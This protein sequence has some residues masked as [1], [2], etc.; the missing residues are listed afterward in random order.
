M[1]SCRALSQCF[2]WLDTC[3]KASHLDQIHA[4]VI[5]QGL[6]GDKR[7]SS[8]IL[9]VCHKLLRSQSASRSKESGTSFGLYKQLL[10]CGAT[11]SGVTFS[12]VL[13]ACSHLKA[14]GLVMGIHA[15]SLALG[16]RYDSLVLNSLIHGYVACELVGA[17]HEVFDELPDRDC[18]AWTELING[19]ARSGCA[20]AALDLFL[21]MMES[22]V[23]PDE[24][25]IVAV[26]TAFSQ[27]GSASLARMA[28]GLACKLGA[29]DNSYVVNALIDMHGKCGS[30]SDAWELFDG[31]PQKDVV[32]YN[33][34]VAGFARNGDMETAKRLFHRIP[35]KNEVSWSSLIN[36]YLQNDCFREVLNAYTEMIDHGRVVPNAAAITC[37]VAA[38]AHLGALDLGRKIHMNLDETKL[39]VDTVLST[40]LVD[41]YAKCGCISSACALFGRIVQKSEVSWNVMIMGLAI[42]GQAAECLELFSEMLKVG[43][44]PTS[45]TFTGVL[46]ACAHVGWLEVGKHYFEKMTKLYRISPSPEHLCCM[47]HLLGRAGLISEAFQLVR[48][49]PHDPDAATWGALLSSCRRHGYVE[50]GDVIARKILELEP[51][52]SG[53]FVQLSSMLASA[54]KWREVQEIRKIMKERGVQNR[55]GW[56][57]F[58]LDGTVH[59]FVI[60]VNSHPRIIDIYRVLQAIDHHM[61][62]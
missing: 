2:S 9:H 48:D 26:C 14:P 6:S 57:W 21:R 12:L 30:V 5:A 8:V 28:E 45:T 1:M 23:R 17:A 29:M 33:S 46:S 42:H 38:C 15:Q 20:E 40:A 19:Y 62:G 35:N 41:M 44:K 54:S 49:S 34:M 37:T 61:N 50:L 31:L 22:D 47:V 11:P 13:K 60:G 27:F 24:F 56:S 36:G 53:A 16:F 43:M 4:Q 58:E 39:C 25:S 10:Q 55:C 3:S 52:H 18:I 32:S 59:E 7:T 51:Y